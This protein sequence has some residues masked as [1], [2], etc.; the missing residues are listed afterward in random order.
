MPYGKRQARHAAGRLFLIGGAETREPDGEILAAFVKEAGDG[1]SRILLCGAPLDDPG[2]T[3][4]KYSKTFE[5]LGATVVATP[6]ADRFAGEDQDLIDELDQC[7]A[8]FMTGGDQLQAASRIAGTTFGEV[9]GE[10]LRGGKF[11]LGGT[12]A[13]AA[14]V[15]SVM[16]IGGPAEG[17][18]RRADVS[19]A[20]GLGYWPNVLVDTHFNERGR[21]HRL[22]VVFAQNP[23]VLG[24]GLD[25]NTAVIVDLGHRL[26]VLGTGALV[27]FDGRISHSNA[28]EVAA[29]D[30]V[31]VTDATVHVL[32]PGYGFDLTSL[33]PILPGSN[34]PL[35]APERAEG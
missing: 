17:S 35:P 31:A 20:P 14:A 6:F 13:G 34:T 12:S 11:L 10:Q 27:V 29:D 18:V 7:T 16:T 9:L 32:A 2:Q 15:G 28:S 22:M 23:A 30:I 26:H 33:R 8:F 21:I 4:R 5:S 1:K 19:L 25:E 24:V 3:L